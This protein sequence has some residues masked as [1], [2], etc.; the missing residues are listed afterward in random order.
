LCSFQCCFW[1]SA[2]QY[3]ARRQ[4]AHR[5]VVHCSSHCAA[6]TRPQRP[7]SVAPTPS[8]AHSR[9]CGSSYLRKAARLLQPRHPRGVNGDHSTR[10]MRWWLCLVAVAGRAWAQQVYEVPPGPTRLTHPAP[11]SH[12]QPI[13][14]LMDRP[15]QCSVAVIARVVKWMRGAVHLGP[16]ATGLRL[17]FRLHVS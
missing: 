12:L 11:P 2:Q 17:G 6:N 16:A 5:S 9:G 7:V 10:A 15:S 1:C 3:R 14:R 4:R 13:A 8:T